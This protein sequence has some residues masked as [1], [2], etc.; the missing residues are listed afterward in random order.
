MY[1]LNRR[2]EMRNALP[3]LVWTLT[4]I[5]CVAPVAY[6]DTPKPKETPTENVSLNFSKIEVT[7]R[8]DGSQGPGV[9]IEGTLHV[10]SQALL[11]SD[12]TPIGFTLHTNVSDAFAGSL[13]GATSY[14]AVG[15]SEGIPA[16]CQP[17]ACS[18]PFWKLTFRLLPVNSALQSTLLFDETLKTQ[19]AT[20]GTLSKVCVVGQD[21]CDIDVGIP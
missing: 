1:I 11:L 4:T 12:G 8:I 5:A 16:E 9:A 17:T 18:P 19:Y 21:G 3:V 20:D 10:A 7:Y 14:V 2:F 6:A 13:D 15:A